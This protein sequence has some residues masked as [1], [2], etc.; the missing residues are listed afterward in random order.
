MTDLAGAGG[1]PRPTTEQARR[2]VVAAH[3][4][5]GVRATAEY[6]VGATW[7][8]GVW[9][10]AI[11]L[12]V[13]G[14][15][16]AAQ[17]RAGDVDVSALNGPAGSA[18]FFLFVMG[19]VLPLTLVV[20][21]LASGGTRR[22]FLHGTVAG[23]AVVGV[24]FGLVAALLAWA[25]R[26]LYDRLGWQT[27]WPHG[28]LY[29]DGS[30][31]GLVLLV[32]TVFC[33]VYYLSGTTIALGYYRTGGW[34]GTALLPLALVPVALSELV[35]QS[36]FFGEAFARALG[37]DGTSAWLGLAGGVVAAALA[38]VLLHRFVRD[39]PLRAVD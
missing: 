38:V 39:V 21:H 27:A 10:W 37:L 16:V 2:A 32:Q 18:K 17:S 9:F 13:G 1:A 8:I 33:V 22:S 28:Q 6:M 23:A 31:F 5:R 7:Y 25:E 20:V 26:W 3:H 12:A 14:I 4:R 24:T 30:Q 19:I 15:I 35:L 34:L 11:A 36:G 29:D